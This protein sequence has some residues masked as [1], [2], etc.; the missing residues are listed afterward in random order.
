MTGGVT[1]SKRPR[2]VFTNTYRG[3]LSLAVLWG[4]IAIVNWVLLVVPG[5][6]G[7]W[8]EVVGAVLFTLASV[9]FFNSARL[10]RGTS[11]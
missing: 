3:S 7:G 10:L 6:D 11:I 5:S 4:V 2:G 9:L 8:F 1:Q